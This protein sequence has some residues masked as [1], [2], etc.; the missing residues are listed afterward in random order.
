MKPWIFKYNSTGGYIVAA[1]SLTLP[2]KKEPLVPI[3]TIT[4]A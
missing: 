3:V 4:G 1:F 2:A